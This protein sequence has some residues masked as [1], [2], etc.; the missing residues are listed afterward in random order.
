MVARRP[1]GRR[2]TPSRSTS[3][4]RTTTARWP[5]TTTTAR[6]TTT[7]TTTSSSRRAAARPTAGRRSRAASALQQP[8]PPPNHTH[9]SSTHPFPR[10]RCVDC[11]LSRSDFG[12][13]DNYHHNNVDLFW[14]DGFGICSQ[15]DSHSDGYY[16]NYLCMYSAGLLPAT[17]HLPPADARAIPHPLPPQTWPR[18]ATT[19]AASHARRRAR[20]SSATTRSGARRAPS[21]SAA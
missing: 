8:P 15:L 6:P 1:S 10:T 5:S 14:D 16:G 19:A 2:T 20:P 12:G 18:T 13:H 17:A 21:T 7:R 3:S 4:W 9:T 11:D